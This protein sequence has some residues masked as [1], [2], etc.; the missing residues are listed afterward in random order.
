MYFYHS[1]KD[2]TTEAVT[3]TQMDVDLLV[4]LHEYFV[5]AIHI[6]DDLPIDIEVKMSYLKDVLPVIDEAI[7]TDDF[8]GLHWHISKVFPIEEARSEAKNLKAYITMIIKSY[9]ADTTFIYTVDL[10]DEEEL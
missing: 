5:H 9:P 3:M 1:S 2:P 4:H 7:A 6:C 8:S 10:D